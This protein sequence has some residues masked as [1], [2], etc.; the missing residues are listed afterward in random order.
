M[1]GVHD[2]VLKLETHAQANGT[3]VK[4]ENEAPKRRRLVGKSTVAGAAKGEVGALPDDGGV[5]AGEALDELDLQDDGEEGIFAELE[6]PDWARMLLS[7]VDDKLQEDEAVPAPNWFE[8]DD[9]DDKIP[10]NFGWIVE[11]EEDKPLEQPLPLEEPQANRAGVGIED[12]EAEDDDGADDGSW[13]A[14]WTDFLNKDDEVEETLLYESSQPDTEWSGLPKQTYEGMCA[15]LLVMKIR[16]RLGSRKE[17]PFPDEA[18]LE[19]FMKL[20]QE[21]V[22]T[23]RLLVIGL[24]WLEL[25]TLQV[26][27]PSQ[28][29]SQ[30]ALSLFTEELDMLKGASEFIPRKTL[31]TRGAV[32]V[33]SKATRQKALDKVSEMTERLQAA[34]KGE[35]EDEDSFLGSAEDIGKLVSEALGNEPLS[36]RLVSL[37]HVL[38]YMGLKSD[39]YPDTKA[40]GAA[41][42]RPCLPERAILTA[43]R[44]SLEDC[45]ALVDDFTSET[46]PAKIEA[47]TLALKRLLKDWGIRPSEEHLSLLHLLPLE[48]QVHTLL[49]IERKVEQQWVYFRQNTNEEHGLLTKNQWQDSLDMTTLLAPFLAGAETEF[50]SKLLV[51]SGYPLTVMELAKVK[52]KVADLLGSIFNEH[53]WEPQE[54]TR[55]YMLKAPAVPRL[56]ALI[57]LAGL[58]TCVDADRKLRELIMDQQTKKLGNEVLLKWQQWGT[59]AKQPKQATAAQ[60]QMLKQMVEQYVESVTHTEFQPFT[61]AGPGANPGTRATIG[62]VAG[63]TPAGAPPQTPGLVTNSRTPVGSMTPLVIRAAE[64]GFTPKGGAPVTP[65][66]LQTPGVFPSGTQTP[67]VR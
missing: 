59:K 3:G 67:A 11:L 31:Y 10:E 51:E 57:D 25:N 36:L 14:M 6:D 2:E 8:L 23:Q 27:K 16:A 52:A 53:Q 33:P 49:C 65:S 58:D 13:K 66:G 61:P 18:V 54:R 41:L 44:C 20:L 42:T 35:D 50:E 55:K 22:A 12:V 38:E 17:F 26:D 62:V 28:S 48:Q 34:L 32:P 56:S 5:A 40:L 19:L 1:A 37:L 43:C 9:G 24:I 4:P 60:M 64:G 29:L 45:M 21:P 39:P 46:A 30:D 7:V 47:K 15:S 63:R